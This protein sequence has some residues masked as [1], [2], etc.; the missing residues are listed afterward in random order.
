MKG[1]LF[2]LD[3][4]LIDSM[5][6]WNEIDKM[7]VEY[8]GLE[9]HPSIGEK[10]AEAPLSESKKIFSEHFNY[11]ENFD[12]L[13]EFIDNTLDEYYVEKFELKACV[14][15]RLKALKEKGFTMGL[16]TATLSRHVDS[17]L[18]RTGLLNYLDYVFTPDKI[19]I[20][21]NELAFFETA[22]EK[23]GLEA[24][25]VYVFDDALYAI[26]NALA[27]GMV[28]IAVFDESSAHQKHKLQDIS[29]MYIDSFC[30]L[31][32]EVL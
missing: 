5:G 27:I 10:L 17:L 15:E 6:I 28:P 12:D 4:T 29:K 11:E 26:E 22:L 19:G 21:K 8:K 31:D 25:D 30:D 32:V 7:Y 16:S 24:E 20:D 14:K 2:D 18:E 23:M 13:Y 3:G 1:I 9:Y